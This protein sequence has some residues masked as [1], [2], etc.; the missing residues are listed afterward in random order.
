M[1]DQHPPIGAP[2]G[3]P[4]P[5][6]APEWAG[7]PVPPNGPSEPATPPTTQRRGS[8]DARDGQWHRMHPLTPLLQGGLVLL[9]VFGYLI[10]NFRDRVIDFFIPDDYSGYSG[11]GDPVDWVFANNLVFV[12]LLAVIVIVAIFIGGFYL[13]WRFHMFRITD[14]A[15]E[16]KQGILSRKQ[17]RAPL[18]RVQ[19]VN[20]TRPFIAR[21]IG[22]AKLEVVGAGADANVKLEYLSTANAEQVRADILRLASGL[23]ARRV[24]A[25]EGRPVGE[26]Q[27]VH[28]MAQT[29]TDGLTGMMLG[30]EEP[31]V[32]PASVV[33]I[34]I[35][36][37]LLSH[38]LS[39]GTVILVLYGVVV[40]I[41]SIFGHWTLLFGLV[42]AII[43]F[44]AYWI[45]SLMK[46]LRY[47]IAPTPDGVRVTFGLT[48]TIT[49]I[50]PPGRIHAIEIS[51]SLLWRPMGWWRV[52]INRMSGRSA[53]QQSQADPFATLLPVGTAEDV[54]RVLGLVFPTLTPAQSEFIF[55]HGML[56]PQPND[57][58][59]NTPKRRWFVRP[60][61]WKRNG[62]LLA[63]GYLFLRRGV[64]W[65]QL[66]MFPLARAQGIT[67]RQ[68]PLY[69]AMDL[70]GLQVNTVPGVVSTFLYAVDRT[71]LM[72][73]FNDAAAGAIIASRE[74]TSHRWANGTQVAGIS[75]PQA[76]AVPMQAPYGAVP[77]QGVAAPSYPYAATPPDTAP[78]PYAATAHHGGGGSALP[79][80]Q[81]NAQ[82]YAPTPAA[83]HAA[84]PDETH[85]TSDTEPGRRGAG[86]PVSAAGD[87]V[88]AGPG[89]PLLPTN[90]YA[91]GAS[92]SVSQT[93][94][95]PDADADATRVDGDGRADS[96]A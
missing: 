14:T 82:P 5:P 34:P 40:V 3:V 64:I 32:E 9:V 70:G 95:T 49:E 74:D 86:A 51:Q 76:P 58:F 75:A 65:R 38:I 24:A 42:P 28:R 26:G 89:T 19:G 81:A 62:F 59:T 96:G 4:V 78:R 56:G 1:S 69:R 93:P 46:V 52:R 30:A 12:A 35:P 63:P 71:A 53:S 29:V 88:Q 43:A 23:R 90:P 13:S 91:A 85:A 2:D 54:A 61:S 60:F 92:D 15:V 31:V 47:S 72:R 55:R 83:G 66:A 7:G 39:P 17:R 10:A 27:P 20:L 11:E 94:A 45:S 77:P 41:A 87:P 57:P 50:L 79:Y 36:R 22:L 16:V 84:A 8:L 33:N 68:G 67:V 37:M 18:D 21:L 25:A 80:Q 44:G 48:T 73:L 6:S